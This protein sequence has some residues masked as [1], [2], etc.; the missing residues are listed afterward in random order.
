MAPSAASRLALATL[1][2]CRRM[3]GHRA[4]TVHRTTAHAGCD[5]DGQRAQASSLPP[6]FDD[7]ERRTFDYFWELGNPANGLVPDRWPTPSFVQH[8]RGRLRAD[9]LCR[10]R[11]ARL[12]HARPGRASARWRRCASSHDAPQG[13]AARGHD[14]LQG[15]LLPLPRHGDRRA[16]RERASCRRSTPRCCWPACCSASPTSTATTATRREIRELAEQLYRRV[17]W[18]LGAGARAARSSI[19]WTPEERLPRPTTGAATTRRCW[20]TSSRSARRRI[21][22][23]RTRATAWTSTYD[24]HLGHVPRPGAPELRAAVRPPVLAR[25]D[26]LPRHPGRLH[27]RP[28]H[29]LLREHPARDARRSAP[30]RSPIRRAGTATARTSGA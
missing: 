9:R 24:Q 27:A 16:L 13:A 26:R 1:V 21:R 7:L 11:R 2:A 29:R 10:R 25:L 15:L 4:D 6:L 8:R 22:S 30:T 28:R 18:R 3:Q 12:D 17:D 14:R 5:A 19:G 23:T 20:S